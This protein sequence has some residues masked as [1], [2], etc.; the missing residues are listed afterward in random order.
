MGVKMKNR[1][2]GVGIALVV[3]LVFALTACGELEDDARVLIDLSGS[4]VE[5]EGNPLGEDAPDFQLMGWYWEKQI[6]SN[7]TFEWN[8]KNDGTVWVVHCCL[9]EFPNQFSYYLDGDIL[10]TYGSEMGDPEAEAGKITFTEKNGVVKLVRESGTVFIRR[11][12][13]DPIPDFRFASQEKPRRPQGTWRN[14][15]AEFIFS[16]NDGLLING[17]SEGGVLRPGQ[18]RYLAKAVDYKNYIAIWGPIA[19]EEKADVWRYSYGSFS[20]SSSN[21]VLT[22]LNEDGINYNLTRAVK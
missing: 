12:Q 5:E 16:G 8:F 6:S 9:D 21:L 1:F 4:Q 11:G 22:S 2:L 13:A 19:D 17:L 14:N 3:I 7:E 10:V 18:Y 15:D 20:Q